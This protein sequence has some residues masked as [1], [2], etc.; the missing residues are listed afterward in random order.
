MNS[1]KFKFIIL[2]V[3][4]ILLGLQYFP[5]MSYDIGEGVGTRLSPFIYLAF[6]ILAVFSLN[7]KKT[8]N[9]KV[10]FNILIIYVFIILSCLLTVAF[11]GDDFSELVML[12][13]PVM[14]IIIGY[15]LNLTIKQFWA[16]LF[17][18]SIAMVAG[19]LMQ[20]FVYG[21]GF[22]I[23]EGYF[24]FQK[25]ALGP[26]IST[27][28]SLCFAYLLDY[29]H[30]K[31]GNAVALVLFLLSAVIVLNIRARA[32]LVGGIMGVLLVFYNKYKGHK[33]I[34]AS[35]ILAVLLSGVYLMLPDSALE[36]INTSILGGS[37][38]VD[39]TSGRTER[40]IAAVRF[41][42]TNIFIGRLGNS[43]ES[44]EQ[45]HNY[46]LSILYN[47][48]LIFSLPSIVLYFYL[49]YISVFRG[50]TYD[51][52]IDYHIG[53]IVLIIPMTVSLAEYTFPYGPGTATVF[54]FLL[55]GLA[56]RMS[57]RKLITE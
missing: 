9:C 18:Y 28:M 56:L 25:N 52:R 16:F 53:Y 1:S 27:S 30:S 19:G 5:G 54:N 24:A 15:Q 55:F 37:A 22:A 3:L 23:Q 14:S 6:V 21:S 38:S 45:I 32:A 44:I 35:I 46:L 47:R 29:H 51:S 2:C 39:I 20:M 8:F 33:I 41:L 17:I 40:N 50:L 11:F 4:V 48:G 57:Q 49:F 34:G 13:I 31:L 12:A 10:I 36:Y 42:S 43:S 26:M 7:F